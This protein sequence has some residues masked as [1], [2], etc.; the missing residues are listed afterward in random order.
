MYISISVAL[1]I[2][3]IADI[4]FYCQSTK[5]KCEAK[6]SEI[7][8]LSVFLMQRFVQLLSWKDL[9]ALRLENIG[10]YLLSFHTCNLFC[11]ESSHAFK[12]VTPFLFIYY[13]LFDMLCLIYMT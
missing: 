12:W 2:P 1:L 13:L 4:L 6:S 5:K 9:Q 10:S 8:C 7:I 11:K 3:L